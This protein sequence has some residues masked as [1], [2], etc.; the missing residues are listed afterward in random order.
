MNDICEIWSLPWHVLQKNLARGI[1]SHEDAE[2]EANRSIAHGTAHFR[3]A[4]ARHATVSAG[5]WLS[6]AQRRGAPLTF[7]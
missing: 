4:K 5:S 3:D 7:R 6:R 1:R 2:G